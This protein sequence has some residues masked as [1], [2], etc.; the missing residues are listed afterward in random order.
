MIKVSP[1]V[2]AS[3][4]T[5][6]LPLLNYYYYF[7]FFLSLYLFIFILFYF[8]NSLPHYPTNY[9]TRGTHSPCF[10]T[11]LRSPYEAHL[12]CD[13]HVNSPHF[14]F[15]FRQFLVK[16]RSCPPLS[17]FGSS[18]FFFFLSIFYHV[19]FRSRNWTNGRD[20]LEPY[21]VMVHDCDFLLS[22]FHIFK[23]HL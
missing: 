9:P 16:S 13:S 20:K 11:L 6:P 17:N 5:C 2:R 4:P 3:C 1:R 8:S 18:I 10:P 19:C 7:L 23:I 15:L 22:N 21:L 12:P 14:C